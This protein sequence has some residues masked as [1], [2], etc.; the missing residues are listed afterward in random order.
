MLTIDAQVHA[1]ERDHPGRP[2]AAVLPGVRE[3]TGDA[4]VAAMDRVGVDVRSSSR[5][6]L[7][8]ATMRATRSSSTRRIPAGSG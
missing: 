5:P 8:T 7:R 3:A 2:W 4:M 6:S 1:Y